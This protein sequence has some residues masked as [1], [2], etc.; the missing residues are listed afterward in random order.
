M[1]LSRAAV[2][3]A[4]GFRFGVEFLEMEEKDRA[5]LNRFITVQADPWTGTYD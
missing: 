3:W 5:R 4:Q 1:R 2:C